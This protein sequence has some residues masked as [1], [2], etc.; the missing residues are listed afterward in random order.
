MSEV[1]PTPSY[2]EKRLADLGITNP[3][4][5]TVRNYTYGNFKRDQEGFQ[6]REFQVFQEDEHGNIRI[7]YPTLEGLKAQWH[8]KDSKVAK[9]YFITRLKEPKGDMKYMINKGSGTLPFLPKRIIE[10][11][12]KR[13]KIENLFLTE[14]AFK[15]FKGDME[16][17]DII[18]LTSITHAKDRVTMGLHDDIRTIIKLCNVKRVIWLVDGDCNRLSSKP[19]DQIDDLYRRPHQFFNSA[20]SIRQYLDEFD[21]LEKWFVHPM[22]DELD[23]LGNPKGLD[24]LLIATKGNE[25]EVIADLLSFSKRGNWRYFHKINMTYGAGDV[26]R[27]FHLASVDDFYHFH[28]AKRKE[29]KDAK[30]FTFNGTKYQYNEEKNVCV[31]TIPGDAKNFFRVGDQYHEKIFIPNKY[32]ELEKTFHRR[33]KGTIQDD[34][35]KDFCKHIPKYKA[36]CNSPDHINYQEVIH[37]CYNLY[38]PFEHQ[39]DEGECEAT[40]EFL[41]HIFGVN[42]LHYKHP[43]REGHNTIN[44]LDLGLDYLQLLYQYPNQTLPILCLVS[45]ENATG[46]STFAKWLKM[47]FTQNVAIVGNAELADNFNASWAT[48]LL[49]ICDEAKIDKQVVVEKVK[50]LSTADK[51][52]MNAKG[53]D[54]VEIEFFA[55]FIFLTNNEDNFIY[56]SEDDVRYWIRKVP[57]LPSHNVR[58]LEQMQDEIPAFLYMLN[59]RK[60]KTPN[61]HRAWF[62]PELIKTEALSKVVANSKPTIEK[63]IRARIREMFFDFGVDEILMS[64]QNV[65]EEFFRGKYES[66]YV[67]KVMKD[68]MKLEQ[69]NNGITS[70]YKYPRY[71]R[72]NEGNGVVQ[73][74]VEVSNIGRPYVF[75][76]GRFLLPDEQNNRKYED[77]TK[78]TSNTQV[79]LPF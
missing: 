28:V 9:D 79:D 63:E 21:S 47:I 31:I 69:Y 22:S 35:G 41:R 38:G 29:L 5:H 64:P 42:D 24:D 6:E 73:S 26:H 34:Y 58:L 14:G 70:R 72:R 44:E 54:H 36:F 48:R 4:Q 10:K 40:M 60:I 49:V 2:F 7:Y 77:G 12:Q 13:E 43:M 50:S 65:N 15:A 56:A 57:K 66:N 27:Y 11:Y 19:I 61:V 39:P 55:K 53:K 51:I 67:I 3:E 1:T 30:D 16:G 23:D 52:L 75:P 78:F 32:K 62:D 45:R 68:E 33:M 46:K 76:V 17:L 18:G 59:K 20:V 25:K 74:I 37:S 71:E 8:R